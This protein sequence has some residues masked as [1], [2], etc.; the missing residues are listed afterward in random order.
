MFE[1]KGKSRVLCNEKESNMPT[2]N[3]NFLRLNNKTAKTCGSQITFRN[4]TF[5]I[6]ELKNHNSRELVNITL[7][8]FRNKRKCKF[9][10]KNGF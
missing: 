7:L 8:V 10:N 6:G 1:I 9:L 3:S 2:E 4:K 5:Y